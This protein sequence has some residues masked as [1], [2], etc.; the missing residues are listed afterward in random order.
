[1]FFLIYFL[2]N[3]EDGGDSGTLAEGGIQKLH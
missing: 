3:G 1:M 2:A